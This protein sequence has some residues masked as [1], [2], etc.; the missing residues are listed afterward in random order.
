[1]IK[2]KVDKLYNG[3][4]SVRDYVYKKALRKKE[5]LGIIHGN[6]FMIV[7]YQNLKKA[8]ILTNQSFVSMFNGKKYKLIDFVWK[9]YKEPNPN[10]ERLL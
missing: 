8:K 10:Q 1:M 4:V 5:S 2:A 7:P 9:P 6:E 3:R